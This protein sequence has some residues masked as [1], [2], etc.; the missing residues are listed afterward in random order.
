[1]GRKGSRK[2]EHAGEEV[3]A[4]PMGPPS[5]AAVRTSLWKRSVTFTWEK[6]GGLISGF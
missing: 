2:A 6:L 5:P 3:T 4:G 1:M